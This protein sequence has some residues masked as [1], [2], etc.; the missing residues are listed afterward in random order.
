[1][2]QLPK[3]VVRLNRNQKAEY[4]G[5]SAAKGWYIYELQGV[6]NSQGGISTKYYAIRSEQMP[7]SKEAIQSAWREA[8]KWLAE[9]GPVQSN[10]DWY[11]VDRS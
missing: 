8:K 2:A 9:I 10:E 1:M 6:E 11:Y 5:G 4:V 3:N 7:T